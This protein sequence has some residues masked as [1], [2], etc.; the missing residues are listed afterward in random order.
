[1]KPSKPLDAN[2]AKHL[3]ANEQ[4]AGAEGHAGV[5]LSEGDKAALEAFLH[6]LTDEEFAGGAKQPTP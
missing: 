5:N 6:T 1:V 3:R 4:I 2:L